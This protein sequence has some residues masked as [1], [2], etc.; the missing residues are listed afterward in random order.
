MLV[1][2]P[3][4]LYY[5]AWPQYKKAKASTQWPKASG[6]ITNSKLISKRTRSKKRTKT[7]YRAAIAFKYFIKNRV[8]IGDEVYIGHSNTSSSRFSAERIL[9]RYPI[10]K[11]VSVYYDP[12]NPNYGILEPGTQML[13]YLMLGGSLLFILIGLLMTVFEGFKAA[14]MGGAIGAAVFE[15]IGGRKKKTVQNRHS[16]GRTYSKKPSPNKVQVFNRNPKQETVKKSSNDPLRSPWEYQWKIYSRSSKKVY[17]PYKFDQVQQFLNAGKITGDHE[18]SPVGGEG[19][20][21]VSDIVDKQS[22]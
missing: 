8:H 11:D 13:H 14:L 18:C 2:G 19:H 21:W 10:G 5:Q 16:S 12:K 4:F 3:A 1:I 20:F 6:E 7:T 15:A 9:S 17:G 22:A